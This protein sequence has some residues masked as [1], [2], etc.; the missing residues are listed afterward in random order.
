MT[1]DDKISFILSEN[2]AIKR[3]KPLDILNEDKDQR[4]ADENERFDADFLLMT[5]ELAKMIDDIVYSLG[6]QLA[7]PL[8]A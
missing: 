1:W 6:G 8:T 2:L 5:S 4:T 7:D 3:I